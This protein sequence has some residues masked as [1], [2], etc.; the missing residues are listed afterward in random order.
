MI[1]DKDELLLGNKF[2]LLQIDYPPQLLA[3]SHQL[4]GFGLHKSPDR[5]L[6][7]TSRLGTGGSLYPW[8]GPSV[9]PPSL[10]L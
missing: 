8:T 7:T 5:E 2:R 1:T 6:E 3:Q 10:P 4:S 9:S